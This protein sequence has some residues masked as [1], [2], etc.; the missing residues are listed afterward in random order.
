MYGSVLGRMLIPLSRQSVRPETQVFPGQ[1]CQLKSFA[2]KPIKIENCQNRLRRDGRFWLAPS[3]P[4]SKGYLVRHP[5]TV[6]SNWKLP[7][8]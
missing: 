7:F 6:R 8:V 4:P 2:R 1:W 5:V 3:P